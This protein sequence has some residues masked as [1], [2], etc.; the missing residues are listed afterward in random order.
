VTKGS[1]LLVAAL[2]N[3][4]VACKA[5]SSSFWLSGRMGW[6]RLLARVTR[7]L[8]DLLQLRE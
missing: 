8:W 3:E 1:D 5:R 4:G 7:R 2:E 6:S